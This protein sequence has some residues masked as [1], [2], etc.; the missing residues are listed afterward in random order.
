MTQP[1]DAELVARAKRGEQRALEMLLSR[2]QPH[3]MRFGL[4]MCGRLEDA[5]DVVQESMIA[6]VRTLP[7]FRED[8]SL[9]TWL[10]TIA[11]SFCIKKRRRSK[12]AP[13]HEASFDDERERLTLQRLTVNSSSPEDMASTA[14]LD[15][16]VQSA[17]LALEPGQREVLVLRDVEGLSASEVAEVTGLSV[18][19][20]KSKLHR[21]RAS[22]RRALEPV[23][24]DVDEAS[25]PPTPECPDIEEMFS[26]SL[27]GE[28]DAELCKRMQAHVD[29]CPRCRQACSTLSAVLRTCQAAPFP[30]VPAPVQASI[31]RAARLLSHGEPTSPEG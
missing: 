28:I 19:A 31:R 12:F 16:A 1:N 4:R 3:L 11:R 7:E 9:S 8:A 29:Q 14:E 26:R 17:I 15:A 20:V 13:T 18:G 21:A 24:G 2:Y 10:Y 5:E 6:A 25:A 27:E 22:L 30:E 23:L